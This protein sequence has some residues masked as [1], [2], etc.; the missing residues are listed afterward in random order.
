[1]KDVYI[2]GAGMTKFGLYN[3]KKLPLK[4]VYE[5]GKEACLAALDHAGINHRKIQAAYCGNVGSPP[6][7]AQMILAQIGIS[8]IPAFNHENGCASGS[9]ALRDAY[10]SIGCGIHDTAIVIGAECWSF[11]A[12]SGSAM[13]L[14]GLISPPPGTNLNQD[15]AGA[16]GPALLALAGKAHMNEYGTTVEQFARIAVK[17]KRNA[18]RNPYAQFQKEITL[19]EVL[20]SRMI[21]DPITK[22]QCCPQSDGAAALILTNAEVAG[23]YSGKPV[24]LA[25]LIETSAKYKGTAGSLSQFTCFENISKQAYEAVG[26][27]PEDLDVVEVHDDFSTLELI[28]YEDLGLCKRGEGGRFIDEGLC[29]YGGEVVVSPSGGL[30]GK[31][32]PLG[33]TGV[34]Q[35]VELTWQLRDE[36]GARQVKNAKIGLAHNGGGIGDGYEPGA[37]T[38]GILTR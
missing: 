9:S 15:I 27:G 29:D 23:Q 36:C 10:E 18:A 38:I 13:A 11:M 28:A 30:L 21:C 8:G 1:M 25:A 4:N 17:N 33:A 14:S 6:N 35:F 12:A 34:A 20:N 3:G 7:C 24:K 5:L 22:L 2:I 31:G 19:E 37:V 26:V 32:H 16:F